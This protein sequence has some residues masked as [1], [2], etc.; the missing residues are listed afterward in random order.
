MQPFNKAVYYGAMA[1][2]IVAEFLL[3]PETGFL[4]NTI[5]GAAFFRM[6]QVSDYC[7]QSF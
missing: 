1:L 7:W 3:I 6:V 2:F 4:E 5:N